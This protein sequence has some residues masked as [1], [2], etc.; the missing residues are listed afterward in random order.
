MK[1]CVN[2][3][4]LVVSLAKVSR[5]VASKPTLPILR[6][7]Y[8]S[9]TVDGKVLVMTNNLEIG[10]L[11]SFEAMV[12]EEGAIVLDQDV[13]DI[14]KALPDEEVTI[15]TTEENQKVTIASGKARY[16][17]SYIDAKDFPQLP[18]ADGVT[19]TLSGQFF[20][21]AIKKVIVSTTVDECMPMLQGV[22]FNLIDGALD[23]V[24]T[25]KHRLSVVSGAANC[26]SLTAIITGK[27]LLDSLKVITSDEVMITINERGCL[28]EGEETKMYARVISG[29]FF[30]YKQFFEGID[31][32]TEI[33]ANTQ[34]LLSSLMRAKL[35]LKG[36]GACVVGLS[37]SN[38]L[39]SVTA[40]A[41]TKKFD[42]VVNVEQKG[43]DLNIGFNVDY[44]IDGLK[45][46]EEDKVT[47]SFRS[48]IE[49]CTIMCNNYK[50]LAL[51]VRQL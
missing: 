10:I 5:A 1:I 17:L 16:D 15:D 46:V 44:M 45:Q 32:T 9:A 3:S 24:C 36:I 26:E 39:L 12:I 31:Y 47:L 30:K 2:K 6:G 22:F 41:E 51:P 25:D 19:L 38:N 37:F 35:A 14:A 49:P 27:A 21:D 7:I 8:M 23:I 13:L 48:A 11:T 29:E 34:E 4:D 33:T 28:I 42:E 20:K 43:A 18:T 50:Y 40:K